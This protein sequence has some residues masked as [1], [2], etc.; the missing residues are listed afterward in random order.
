MEKA[1]DGL[2]DAILP[3]LRGHIGGLEKLRRHAHL[4]HQ[5]TSF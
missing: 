5:P 2:L 3:T 1:Y 4:G